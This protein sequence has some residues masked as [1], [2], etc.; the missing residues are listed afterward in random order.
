MTKKS[1]LFSVALYDYGITPVSTTVSATASSTGFDINVWSD[2]E[3][4]LAPA[5]IFSSP[6]KDF[7]WKDFANI[8]TKL[9]EGFID[10]D[11]IDHVDVSGVDGLRA[12]CFKYAWAS[13]SGGA[14]KELL[15]W[16]LTLEEDTIDYLE[17]NYD[18]S[19]NGEDL[20]DFIELSGLIA[21]PEEH[22]FLSL[23]SKHNITGS[24]PSVKKLIDAMSREQ[25]LKTAREK[26]E[27]LLALAPFSEEIHRI[28]NKYRCDHISSAFSIN[29]RGRSAFGS[30]SDKVILVAWLEDY[31]LEN[32][33]MPTGKHEVIITRHNRTSGPGA[34]DFDK[35]K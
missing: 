11:A 20:S 21:D 13:G 29:E 8:L 16:I 27:R 30:P 14:Y 15:D 5:T 7:T 34:V 1:T 3:E 24:S 25:E 22:D 31:V 12:E 18:L 2:D 23:L 32:K 6:S 9:T 17:S 19:V 33:V 28:A 35:L 4:L 10:D 26:E